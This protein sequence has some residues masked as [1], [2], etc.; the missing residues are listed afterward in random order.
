MCINAPIILYT[1]GIL[2][3]IEAI[4]ISIFSTQFKKAMA[5]MSKKKYPLVKLGLAELSMGIILILIAYFL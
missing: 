4:T 1:I 3:A 2:M 5:R